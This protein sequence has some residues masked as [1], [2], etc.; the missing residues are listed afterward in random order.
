MRAMILVID[1]DED[2]RTTMAEILSTEGFATK[3]VSN[4][5]EAREELERRGKEIELILL[6]Y[7]FEDESVEDVVGQLRSTGCDQPIVLCTARKVELNTEAV[8]VLCK[9]FDIE[10][11]V[12]IVRRH[13]REP[14]AGSTPDGFC[15]KR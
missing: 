9:P 14:V 5:L 6:D 15:M 3:A 2:I 4:Q 7:T 10:D 8:P 1:R 13:R 11:M 12:S